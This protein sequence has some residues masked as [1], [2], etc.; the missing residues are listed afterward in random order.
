M[1]VHDVLLITVY[2]G[3]KVQQ[4]YSMYT[5]TECFMN[6]KR[7]HE[8]LCRC[9]SLILIIYVVNLKNVCHQELS[10]ITFLKV[11]NYEN[12]NKYKEKKSCFKRQY[13]KP[14]SHR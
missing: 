9:A 8:S 13:S 1:K 10:I 2:Y 12:M 7:R 3:S 5:A 11:E 6:A 4:V 14:S